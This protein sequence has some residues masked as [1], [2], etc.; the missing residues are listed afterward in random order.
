MPRR[1]AKNL[2]S[3]SLL[4]KVLLAKLFP[5]CAKWPPLTLPSA[6]ASVPVVSKRDLALARG[7]QCGGSRCLAKHGYGSLDWNRNYVFWF[8][9]RQLRYSLRRFNLRKYATPWTV[10]LPPTV[11]SHPSLALGRGGVIAAYESGCVAIDVT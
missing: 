6:D 5:A 3:G 8:D 9:P 10:F 4:Y 2:L 1:A 7:W 11:G